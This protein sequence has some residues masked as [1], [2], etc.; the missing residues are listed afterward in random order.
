MLRELFKKSLAIATGKS[1]FLISCSRMEFQVLHWVFELL[2]NGLW[3]ILNRFA[4][5]CRE[6]QLPSFCA[7]ACQCG[8]S[9]CR[10]W[11]FQS[12]FTQFCCPWSCVESVHPVPSVWLGKLITSGHWKAK[13]KEEGTM[14]QYPQAHPLVTKLPLTR[15]YLLKSSTPARSPEAE[16]QAI[17]TWVWGT[18]YISTCKSQNVFC[19]LASRELE[20]GTQATSVSSPKLMSPLGAAKVMDTQ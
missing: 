14:P 13:Q 12:M 7:C 18:F 16:N 19:A 5:I 8:S 11:G 15:L 9:L 6:V 3:S 4:C 10:L 2:H 1:V 17:S 20:K